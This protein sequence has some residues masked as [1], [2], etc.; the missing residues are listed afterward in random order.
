MVGWERSHF[1]TDRAGSLTRKADVIPEVMN[2]PPHG[3]AAAPTGGE[4]ASW[5]LAR[6][7]QLSQRANV[8][9]RS[10]SKSAGSKGRPNQPRIDSCSGCP[11][12]ASAARNWR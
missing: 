5:E 7:R 1:V 6:R 10:G 4:N 3:R 11:G 8:V 9:A 12:S 2:G